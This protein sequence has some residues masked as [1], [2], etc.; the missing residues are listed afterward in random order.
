MDATGAHAKPADQVGAE[1]RA[2]RLAL[3]TSNFNSAIMR[4][5]LGC[6]KPKLRERLK[7]LGNTCSLL[8]ADRC[9]R[10]RLQ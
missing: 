6:K 10:S 8:P 5:Q 9:D 2:A 3:N 7:P 1:G 4:L